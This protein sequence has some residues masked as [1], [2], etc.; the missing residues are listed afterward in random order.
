MTLNSLIKLNGVEVTEHG[1]L[2]S[3]NNMPQ[4]SDVEL[5]SGLTRR[6]YK[7]MNSVFVCSWTYLPNV[8]AKTVD[9]RQ[10]RDY[11]DSLVSSGSNVL[12][13]IK[14]SHDNEF[15]SYQCMITEYTEAMLRNHLQSQCRYYDVT[16][17]LES[18]D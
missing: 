4:N 1:R 18:L 9:G 13:E 3:R 16:L 5:A 12:L 6:F 11:L 8:A 17:T 10:G 7:E 2:F 14:E 15:A